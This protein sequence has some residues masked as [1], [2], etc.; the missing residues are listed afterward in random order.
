[1]VSAVAEVRRVLGPGSLR[2]A[3][4][5]LAALRLGAQRVGL[6]ANFN[7]RSIKDGIRRILNPDFKRSAQP[8]FLPP[9]VSAAPLWPVVSVSNGSRRVATYPRPGSGME[10]IGELWI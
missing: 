1:M 3:Y 6:L 9:S 2:F 4:A 8:Q 7:S 5:A 10:F